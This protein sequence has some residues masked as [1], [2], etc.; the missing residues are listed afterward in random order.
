M[1]S[2]FARPSCHTSD[3]KQALPFQSWASSP[4]SR[5]L[6]HTH[7]QLGRL[8][9]F[10]QVHT[11]V[12]AN[13]S[14][15]FVQGWFTAS[16]FIFVVG[17][18]MADLGSAMPTSGGLYYWSMHMPLQAFERLSTHAFSTLFREPK[19]SKRPVISC[20]LQQYSWSRGRTLFDRLWVCAH[21]LFGYR[22]CAR[23]RMGAFERYCLRG[24]HVL[25]ARTRCTRLDD[26]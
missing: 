1:R 5:R 17:L 20:R 2:S 18:A 8:A 15:D 3:V 10:G 19:K 7:S 16:T 22:N 23:R 25:C 24:L 11:A 9:W 6:L 26:I 4:P 21:V 12:V 13:K 14:I